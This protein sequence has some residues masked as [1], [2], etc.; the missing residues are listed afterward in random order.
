M[1]FLDKGYA[2]CFHQKHLDQANKYIL[3]NSRNR[4]RINECRIAEKQEER[5]MSQF[6]YRCGVDFTGMAAGQFV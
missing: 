6:L 1:L 3:K 5:L 2:Y 4:F